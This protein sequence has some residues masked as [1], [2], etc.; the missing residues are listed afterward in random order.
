MEWPKSENEIVKLSIA[1]LQLVNTVLRVTASRRIENKK[2]NNYTIYKVY[3]IL[4]CFNSKISLSKSICDKRVQYSSLESL[5][6][7]EM[8]LKM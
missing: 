3:N 4:F 8:I 6:K 7:K 2:R 5:K 1:D